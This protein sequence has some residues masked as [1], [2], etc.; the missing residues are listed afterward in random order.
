MKLYFAGAEAYPDLLLKNGATNWLMAYPTKRIAEYIN[1]ANIF[2]DCGAFSVFNK[3]KVVDHN[4]Y[5]EFIQKIEPG[6]FASLD[7]IGDPEQTK[8]NFLKEVSKGLN[9]VPTFHQG[10]SSKYLEFYLDECGYISLGGMVGVGTRKLI[11]FIDLC[12]S[13]IAKKNPKVKVHAFGVLSWAILSRFPFYSADG[14]SWFA[15]S[16]RGKLFP[17]GSDWI[18]TAQVD[19]GTERAKKIYGAKIFEYYPNDP[20]KE[21]QTFRGRIRNEY[22][23]RRFLDLEKF[24]TRLWEKKGVK[25]NE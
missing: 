1:R 10:E 17:F 18:K 15:G 2:V 11:P 20:S 9:P 21:E 16:K 25:W 14:T 3:K 24:L 7:V 13:I 5:I 19:V 23:I 8:E 12:F 4:S 22:N 6:C